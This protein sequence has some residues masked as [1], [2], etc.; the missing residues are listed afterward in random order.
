MVSEGRRQ[1]RQRLQKL[2]RELFQFD[3]S[4]L[5]FGIYRILNQ[6]RDEIERFIERDLLE[7]VDEELEALAEADRAD[8]EERLEEKREQL[9]EEAFEEDGS[10]KEGALT[11]KLG[12]E[13]Q[14]LQQ[15]LEAV[16]VAED[17]EARIFNDLYRFFSRYYREG[18]F[19]AERR[20]SSREPKYIVPYNGEEVLLHWANRDQ[21]YVK[22]TERFADY[23]F[24]V[25]NR[26]VTFRL[27]SAQT[28]QDDVQG[29]T[30]YFMLEDEEPL[31]L[32]EDSG[33]LEIRFSY[34]PLTEKDEK[35]VLNRYNADRSKSDQRKR[36]DRSIIVDVLKE[37]IFDRLERLGAS[38]VR[39]KLAKSEDDEIGRSRLK[40]HLNRYTARHEMDYFVHKDLGGF[41]R[42]ELDFF[43]KNEILE[44]DDLAGNSETDHLEQAQLRTKVIRR[45]A[46]RVIEFLAQIE[47]FQKQLFEKKKFVIDTQYC[48]TLDRVAEDL[49]EEILANEEQLNAWRELYA[50]DRWSDELEPPTDGMDRAFLETHPYL[51][52][53][54]AHFDRDFTDRLLANFEDLEAATDGLL[55]HG[56]NFQTLTL[57]QEKYHESID[58]VYAD[59]PYNTVEGTFIYKNNYKHSSWITMLADRL[60]AARPLIS[61][62]GVLGIAIDDTETNYLRLLLDSIFGRQ[63]YISTIVAEVNPAGQNLRPNVPAR[64]HDY[65]HVY[66]KQA[67]QVDMKPRPLTEEERE[68]Y[69]HE[70][71]KGRYYWDNLRRRGGN[72]RPSDR[73]NQWY[74]LYVD[75]KNQR[76]STE[77][78]DGS[79]E[80]WPVDPKGER[81]IWRVKPETARSEIK[82]G[83]ISVIEKSGSPEVVKKTRMPEGKK[84]KTVWAKSKY[85]ATTYGSKLL[86]NILGPNTFSYPKSVHLVRDCI[87]HWTR[88]DSIIFD[89]FAGSGT[90]AQAI[91]DLN[92][93]D[94]GNRRFILCEMGKY[95]DTIMLLRVKRVAFTRDWKNS[96]PQCQDGQSLM[97]KYQRLESYEDTLNNLELSRLGEDQLDLYE[98]FDDYL[99]RYMLEIE[100]RESPSLLSEHT[101]DRPFE[102][103]LDIQQGLESPETRTVDLVETFHYLLGMEV[104]NRRVKEHQDRRYV[105]TSGRRKVEGGYETVLTVWRNRENL[106]LEREAEWAEQLVDEGRADRIFTNGPSHIA[107]AQPVELVFH[108][109]MGG[110]TSG[111]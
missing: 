41:L 107:K 94:G 67:D 48:V 86:N 66:G 65:F 59:P 18:D 12:R 14:Q 52:V 81:R 95:F 6:R 63:N 23:R 36:L 29:E 15:E 91:M 37:Q 82:E 50:I 100:S 92:R 89:P 77:P 8:I 42:R 43:L 20:Y 78:F 93:E 68:K 90:T 60:R 76:V 11:T 101:F 56:E 87:Y 71:E 72:S 28:A 61:E 13:Y 103:K 105:L 73:P 44:L 10:L 96:V 64:S 111:A 70:D 26:V 98:E 21:Y 27:V 75:L 35:K 109:A 104:M 108:Q 7:A 57:L 54:T 58:Y 69:P 3:V 80:V 32:D 25:N 33:G 30:R 79:N 24:R 19:L 106:D 53:D 39:A 55:I 17:T 110:T 4:D 34:R 85:S 40:Q 1:N 22:T 102:Y 83:E 49:Y 5:D 47:D 31:R 74:P 62:E 9:G 46:D 51:M 45:I 38:E 2:L 97:V 84:P 99:L 16:S 88:D